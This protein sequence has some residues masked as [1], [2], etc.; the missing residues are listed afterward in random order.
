MIIRSL[1][2]SAVL[3]FTLIWVCSPLVAA[4]ASEKPLVCRGIVVSLEGG[5]SADRDGAVQSIAEGF[6]LLEG[7]VIVLRTGAR[8]TVLAASGQVLRLEGATEYR[9]VGPSEEEL[10]DEVAT[11]IRRQ[12]AQWA[13]RSRREVLVLRESPRDWEIE[14]EAPQQ[15]I[16]APGGRVRRDNTELLWGTIAGIDTYL[17]TLVSKSGGEV[18]RVVRG[19]RLELID[20]VEGEE[21]VWSV[22]PSLTGWDS[23]RTWRD[24]YVMDSQDEKLLDLAMDGM[25]DLSAGVLLLCTGRHD[26]AIPRLDAAVAAA[27]NSHSALM[28]R[29]KALWEIGLCAEACEGLETIA[30]RR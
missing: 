22:Q 27:G 11:W 21:Y 13:G 16:P 6:I 24:F 30:V 14:F 10:V 8:C 20:L 9:L 18:S 28:W 1:I 12:F 3:V 29:A 17:V 4:E 25:D 26:E 5:V 19:S 2:I 7:D 15:L 23:D